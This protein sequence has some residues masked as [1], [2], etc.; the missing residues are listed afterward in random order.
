MDGLDHMYKYFVT[1]TK[2]S[3]LADL[4]PAQHSTAVQCPP[5]TAERLLQPHRERNGRDPGDVTCQR[6]PP[7]GDLVYTLGRLFDESGQSGGRR[8]GWATAV[9]CSAVGAALAGL[10]LCQ[11]RCHA[12]E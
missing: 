12:R 11:R 5:G 3:P 10:P 1:G 9:Q 2:D 6:K 7:A 8:L 4:T